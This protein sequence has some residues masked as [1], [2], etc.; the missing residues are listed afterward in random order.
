MRVPQVRE[1]G[2]PASEACWGGK[3]TW[4]FFCGRLLSILWD[5]QNGD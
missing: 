1:P 5:P 4:V 3:L 2:S